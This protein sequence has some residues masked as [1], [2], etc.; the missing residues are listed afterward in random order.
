MEMDSG[1]PGRSLVVRILDD[2]DA[3][4]GEHYAVIDWEGLHCHQQPRPILF[5]A[6]WETPALRFVYD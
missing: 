5:A 2:G 6:F 1:F 4:S 3:L